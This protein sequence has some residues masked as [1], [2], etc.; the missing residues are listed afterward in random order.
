[1]TPATALGTQTN[2]MFLASL[3]VVY[4]VAVLPLLHP[5]YFQ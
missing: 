1:M 2:A 3:L 5:V 4:E